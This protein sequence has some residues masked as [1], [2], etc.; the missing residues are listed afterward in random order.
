M[1]SF[2]KDAFL[3]HIGSSSLCPTGSSILGSA[4]AGSR[5]WGTEPCRS[6]GVYSVQGAAIPC[7][8]P[9][10]W[11]EPYLCYNRHVRMPNHGPIGDHRIY[12]A[13]ADLVS[14][15]MPS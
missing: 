13:Y 3:D 6:K 8:E 10:P 12:F 7:I 11:M 14:V 4:R 9:A 15:T 5:P 2:L 1:L